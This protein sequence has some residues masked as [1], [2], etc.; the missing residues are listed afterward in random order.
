MICPKLA[1]VILVFVPCKD[2]MYNFLKKKINYLYY[3]G[4]LNF[5]N[6]II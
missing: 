5:F 3:I 2:M 4:L 1:I 6:K